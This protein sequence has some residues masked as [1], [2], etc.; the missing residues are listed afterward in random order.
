MRS[1][2]R[3]DRRP[4]F[5]SPVGMNNSSVHPVAAG[6]DF[7]WR[8][9]QWRLRR[10][11]RR[12]NLDCRQNRAGDAPGA[13][14]LIHESGGSRHRLLTLRAFWINSRDRLS[15]LAASRTPP[16]LMHAPLST[17]QTAHGAMGLPQAY[18]ANIFELA[19]GSIP[20]SAAQAHKFSAGRGVDLRSDAASIRRIVREISRCSERACLRKGRHFGLRQFWGHHRR[21]CGGGALPRKGTRVLRRAEALSTSGP[22]RRQVRRH[23]G[24]RSLQLL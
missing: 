21:L 23:S 6:W 19:T 5:R 1:F 18:S 4:G 12:T 2:R 15:F 20:S 13:I 7:A 8:A 11:P 14:V 3:P 16:S 9:G 22:R 17:R 10:L 24:H